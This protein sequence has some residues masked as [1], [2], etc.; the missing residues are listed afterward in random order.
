VRGVYALGDCIGRYLF[1]H[2]VNYEGE[3][4]M[5]TA[6]SGTPVPPIDYGPVPY[7]VFTTPQIAGVGLGEQALKAQGTDYIAGK[8]SY[9]DSTPGMARVSENGF[10]KVLAERSSG[11]LLGAHIVGEE[12]ATMIHLFIAMLKKGGTVS[13]LM[14]MIF[15][16]P[17]L[18]EVARDAVRDAARQLPR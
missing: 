7:A 9:A 18:P 3:Y 1:R 14:D 4:L 13:D 10:A 8:A 12:A 17:A 15:I 16:H 11:R 2:T 6:F 5:R